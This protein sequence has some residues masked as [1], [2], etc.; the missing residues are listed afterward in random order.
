MLITMLLDVAERYLARALQFSARSGEALT[1]MGVVKTQQRMLPLA[2]PVLSRLPSS[3]G[4]R[5][6]SR[7]SIWASRRDWPGSLTKRFCI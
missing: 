6:L 2:S 1:A 4:R 3:S 5:F 7:A